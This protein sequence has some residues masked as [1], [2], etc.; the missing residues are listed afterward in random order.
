MYAQFA[1]MDH[2]LILMEMG[3]RIMKTTA[4]ITATLN[5]WIQ[6][7]TASVMCVTPRRGAEDVPVCSVRRIAAQIASPEPRS[8]SG[9]P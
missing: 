3:L 9:K 5:N 6:M 2:Q 4:P 7:E 1:A 8:V